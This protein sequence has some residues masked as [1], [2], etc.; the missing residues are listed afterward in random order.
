MLSLCTTIW[1]IYRSII[2]PSVTIALELIRHTF[3]KRSSY[4]CLPLGEQVI[5]IDIS[6]TNLDIDTNRPSV[7]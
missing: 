6:S 7:V 2:H 5:F 4:A 3:S 1:A